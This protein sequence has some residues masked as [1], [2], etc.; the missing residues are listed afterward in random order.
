MEMKCKMFLRKMRLMVF[1][2]CMLSCAILFASAQATSAEAA[3]SEKQDA[4][5][6]WQALLE[7]F[8]ERLNA[9]GRDDVAL[10]EIMKKMETFAQ[11]YDGTNEAAVALFN[12][13]G[14]AQSLGDYEI[15]EK[16][17]VNARKQAKDPRLVSAIDAQLSQLNISPGKTPPAFTAQSLDGKQISLKDYKGKVLLLDFWATWCMPCVMELPN[18]EDVYKTYHDQ[19]FEIVSISLDRD[20]Q[21]LRKFVKERELKW[22]HIY[23]NA[24]PEGKSIASQY[25]VASIPT[26]ILI[27]KEGKIETLDLRGPAL[28]KAVARAFGK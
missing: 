10:R 27:G 25:G 26:M 13:S 8:Q 3:E 9:S 19:G 16:T 12:A 4:E 24:M 11:S 15:A 5:K 1:A 14:I 7:S 23:D 18:V 20:E 21:T 2:V 6:V 28:G 17:L 22:T